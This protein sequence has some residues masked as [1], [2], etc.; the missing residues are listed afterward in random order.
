MADISYV[1]TLSDPDTNQVMYVGKANSPRKRLYN[2]IGGSSK[3]KTKSG[4]WI[5]S[6][7][8]SSK[9]P[10]LSIIDECSASEVMGIESEWIRSYLTLN[11]NLVNEGVGEPSFC[12]R[13]P[14]AVK[15]LADNWAII[16]GSPD[17]KCHAC[18]GAVGVEDVS[19]LYLG[20]TMMYWTCTVCL[21]RPLER[22]DYDWD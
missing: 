20:K 21:H 15:F 11:P 10:V 7:I 2:H 22:N 5:K 19:F 13:H 16:T 12:V 1:Y 6:L 3:P 4:W 14:K 9:R 18:K 8:E 17:R